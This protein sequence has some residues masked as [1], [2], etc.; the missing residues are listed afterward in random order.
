MWEYVHTDELTHHGILGMRWGV[1][2]TREQLDGLSKEDRKWVKKK[3]NK[4]TKQA[5]KKTSKELSRYS[6]EL[7]R[8]PGAINKNGKVSAAA[9]N[10]YNRKMAELMTAQVSDLRSPSGKVISFVAKRGEVGVHLALS[11][12]GYNIDQLKN[13]VWSS[14]RVAYKKDKVGMAYE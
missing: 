6:R 7:L 2:R 10:A 14:G 8:T 5:E 12:Q 13:G 1:R 3:S 11:D 4:V 9:I